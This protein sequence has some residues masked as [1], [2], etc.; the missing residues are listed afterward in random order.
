M[1][2]GLLARGGAALVAAA[3]CI[4]PAAAQSATTVWSFRASLPDSLQARTMGLTE[5][6]FRVTMATDGQQLAM[7]F[8]P[9]AGLAQSMSTMDVSGMRLQV[10][11]PA[12][13]DSVIVG[14]VL[15]PEI[16]AQMGGG[17]G[18]RL[19]FAIPDSVTLP[20]IDADSIAAAQENQEA[21][22]RTGRSDVVAGFACNEWT[23]AIAGDSAGAPRQQATLCIAD[24]LP[25]VTRITDAINRRLP[26]MGYDI[27][28]W[29]DNSA[30]MFGNPNAAM[31]RA[32]FEGDSPLTVQL[33][34]ATATAP[35][36][37]FFA[38]PAGLQPVPQEL[39]MMFSQSA[40]K[41]VEQ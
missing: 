38:L 14:V 21:P 33:E 31:L 40:R 35:D 2:T 10:I 37:S 12:A 4:A 13:G 24:S 22:V 39:L 27:K 30:T 5:V 19:G 25:M 1:V 36:P 18:W 17:I 26:K 20:F 41:A 9:G 32:T 3:L 6:D 29:I 7:Q 8:E 34:S 16:A 11:V 23:M 28:Q 15:P